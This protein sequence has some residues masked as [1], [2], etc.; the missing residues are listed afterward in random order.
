MVVWK[1]KNYKGSKKAKQW[2]PQVHGDGGKF[3]QVK[4]RWFLQWWNYSTWYSSSV[5]MVLHISQNHRT[6]QHRVRAKVNY[7]LQLKIIYQEW[8]INCN[9]CAM[10][11]QDINKGKVYMTVGG[12][13]ELCTNCLRKVFLKWK[14]SKK[15]KPQNCKCYILAYGN[16]RKGEPKRKRGLSCPLSSWELLQVGIGPEFIV[17][18]SFWCAWVCRRRGAEKVVHHDPGVKTLASGR[19]KL[20]GSSFVKA[21][22]MIMFLNQNL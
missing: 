21:S 2:L 18:Q 22:F 7:P 15:K 12:V 5:Y 6:V 19:V 10:L 4:H 13:W 17:A 14:K 1:K 20:Q 9:K 3:E 11:I 8:F 16:Y